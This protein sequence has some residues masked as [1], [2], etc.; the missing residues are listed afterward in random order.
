MTV[1]PKYG[2]VHLVLARN[3]TILKYQAMKM[4]L[5]LDVVRRVYADITTQVM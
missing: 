1:H 2:L 4:S 3:V 5:N